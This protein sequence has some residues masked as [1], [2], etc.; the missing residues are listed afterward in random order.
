MEPKDEKKPMY[1]IFLSL[2]GERCLVVGGGN[3]AE[4]KIERLLES[5]ARVVVVAKEVTERITALAA[6]GEIA[7]EKRPYAGGEAG[8]YFLVI[9]ATNDSALNSEVS[10]DARAAGRLVNVVDV[11]EL[12]NFYVPSSLRRGDLQIAVSTAG[13]SPSIA[14]MVREKLEPL[15]PAAYGQLLRRMREFRAQLIEKV[16]EESRRME[17][18]GR[19][20]RS[21]E[22]EKF[23]EGDSAPLE[24]LIKKCV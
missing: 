3:V 9:A 20:A 11:P 24:A 16:P 14:K 15:F 19:V 4:R 21:P 18:Y 8:G 7:L 1:P 23:I 6:S 12:C 13:A 17:I 5:G 22:V 10:G 2:E